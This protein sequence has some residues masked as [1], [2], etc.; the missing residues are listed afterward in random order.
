M[1]RIILIFLLVVIGSIKGMA[2]N[3]P[4]LAGMILLYTQKAESELKSQER[5]MLLQTT[6]HIWLKEEVEGTT[7]LQ[8]EFNNY[9]TSFRGIVVYAAQIYGFYHEINGLIKNMDDFTK[10]LGNNPGNAVAVALST[11]RN[12]IYRELIMNSV[13]IVNDIRIVCMGDN[14]MTEKERVEIVF[15][16]RPKLKLMNKKL[17][18]LT[19]A[20]KYTSFGDVWLDIDEGSHKKV[21]KQ[22]IVKDCLT[23]W[24]R[25]GHR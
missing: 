23:R 5:A 12:K 15:N 22:T 6:G 7:N 19:L 18:R 2:Q 14:K 11:K 3:D 16:I 20:V 8:K 21:N 13:E 4:A 10:Q 17:Q 25:S 1:N 24:K 9:L